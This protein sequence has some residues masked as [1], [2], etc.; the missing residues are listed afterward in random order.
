MYNLE[1]FKQESHRST[2]ILY[3]AYIIYFFGALLKKQQ[4][5]GN[6]E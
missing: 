1:N 5:K 6:V 4:I 2:S 3:T